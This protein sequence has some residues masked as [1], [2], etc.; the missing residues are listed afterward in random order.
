MRPTRAR[1]L[2]VA[3]WMMGAVLAPGQGVLL[4]ILGQNAGDLLGQSGTMLGD[5]DGD[6]F[7]DIAVAALGGGPANEGSVD[8]VSGKTGAVIHALVGAANGDE[9][10]TSTAPCRDLDG[11]GISELLV[12]APRHDPSGLTDA[13]AAYVFSGKTGS[14]IRTLVGTVP[15]G[16]FGRSVTCVPDVNSDAVAEIGVGS[17]RNDGSAP[18][19]G[20]VSVF[21]GATGGLLK[22]WFGTPNSGGNFGW[23]IRGADVNGDGVGDIVNGEWLFDGIAGTNCGRVIVYSGISDTVLH[24]WE[25]PA[26]S[27]EFGQ[28]IGNAGDVDGDG[29]DDVL[30]GA[31]LV[32]TAAGADAGQVVLH[33]GATGGV[34]HSWDG[35]VAGGYFGWTVGSPG[36]VNGDLV[37]DILIGARGQHGAGFPGSAYLYSGATK[38]LLYR[39]DGEAANDTF[40]FGVVT[41]VGDLNADGLADVLVTAPDHSQNGGSSGAAYVFA[42]N[43]L[44]MHIGPEVAFANDT[45]TLAIRGGPPNGLGLPVVVDVNGTSTFLSIFGLVNLDACG[46]WEVSATVPTGLGLLDVTFLAFACGNGGRLRVSGEELLLIR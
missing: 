44:F 15:N 32:A 30:V 22:A 16:Q 23:S 21:S 43:D 19:D 34:L 26:A 35:P 4:K 9:F 33:S 40:G 27:A 14:L 37:P 10:G 13:G 18:S 3:C 1:G 2:I 28:A 39:F 45:V 41:G 6:G 11:D 46:D 7:G 20:E 5:V 38:K 29:C 42:G 31:H 12:G 25:G 24:D 17:A 8:I 36:D